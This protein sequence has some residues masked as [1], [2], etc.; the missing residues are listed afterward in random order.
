MI[1]RKIVR[2]KI[3]F[4]LFVNAAHDGE[5]E[6]RR[7]VTEIRAMP[8]SINKARDKLFH[9]SR[10]FPLWCQLRVNVSQKPRFGRDIPVFYDATKISS[11]FYGKG[12]N[13]AN[14]TPK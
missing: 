6:K 12:A 3:L 4:K 1:R 5:K 7:I 14:F 11:H 13:G 10:F 2:K 9:G 8:H